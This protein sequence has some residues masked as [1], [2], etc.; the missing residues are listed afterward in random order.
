[1]TIFARCTI[2]NADGTYSEHALVKLDDETRYAI[3]DMG[4]LPTIFI[5][6]LLQEQ[7]AL[8]VLKTWPHHPEPNR[9]GEIAQ[10][11]AEGVQWLV[12]AAERQDVYQRRVRRRRQV[13]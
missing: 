12:Q 9:K 1:M 10:L 3:I 7:G 4:R 5:R 8:A 11:T 2:R 6:V 13:G